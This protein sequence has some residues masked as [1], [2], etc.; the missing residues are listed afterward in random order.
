MAAKGVRDIPLQPARTPTAEATPDLKHHGD[1][2]KA[3]AGCT[4]Q[5]SACKD[6]R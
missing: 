6:L 5:A 3:A 4:Y 2:K 1:F